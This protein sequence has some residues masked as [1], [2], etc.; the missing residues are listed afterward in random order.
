MNTLYNYAMHVALMAVLCI[1]METLAPRGA[2]RPAVKLCISILFV[3][4]IAALV[5]QTIGG[6]GTFDWDVLAASRT[7]PPAVVAKTH[8]DLLYGYYKAY[9]DRDEK[10]GGAYG[11][12]NT[13]GQE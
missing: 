13:Q 11:K 9:F 10:E 12:G 3:L 6:A 5:V 8:S 4:S 7:Q 1:L 2:L